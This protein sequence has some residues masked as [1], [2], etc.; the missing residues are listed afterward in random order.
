M[1]PCTSAVG[2]GRPATAH[3][4]AIAWPSALRSPI[5]FSRATLFF[6]VDVTAVMQL[7]DAWSDAPP[8][9]IRYEA[10]QLVLFSQTERG[11][12][13][14]TTFAMPSGHDPRSASRRRGPCIDCRLLGKNSIVGTLPAYM[15][16]AVVPNLSCG[17]LLHPRK[18]M[19]WI[20]RRTQIG[21]WS[22]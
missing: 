11:F 10:P 21:A 4:S 9:L 8:R 13:A 22:E 6:Q 7:V 3:A 15:W 18:R 5:F 1:W 19:A 12:H 14:G 16:F 20:V 17:G 2:A